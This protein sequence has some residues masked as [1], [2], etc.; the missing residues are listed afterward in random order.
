MSDT[1]D[2]EDN[3]ASANKLYSEDI[4][5]YKYNKY[6]LLLMLKELSEEDRN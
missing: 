4:E 3:S 6:D 2:R 1:V 5:V